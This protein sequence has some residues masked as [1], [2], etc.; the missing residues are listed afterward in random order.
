MPDL[1]QWLNKLGLGYIDYDPL[2]IAFT[3]RSYKGMGYN[4]EDNE[5]LEFLGDAVL[6]I[7]IAKVLFADP[8]LSESDMTELRKLYV[9]NDQLAVIFDLLDMKEFI[10]TAKNLKLTKKIKAGVVE[11]FF[12]VVFNEK[13]LS[14]CFLLW[15]RLHDILSGL[16]DF[17]YKNSY[18]GYQDLKN[19]KSTLQEFCLNL[20]F[21]LPEYKLVEKTGPD[22]APNFK[23]KLI[24]K[25]CSNKLGFEEIFETYSIIKPY[26]RTFGFGKNIKSAEMEAAE[27]MCERIG[28]KYISNY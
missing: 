15:N 17:N 27:E 12:G 9:S 13:S 10:R 25:P 21:D 1:G 19:A 24:L 6:D 5:R 14:D 7:I 28:L 26:V 20:N 16:D 4:G 11:A 22:H 18:I 3:H 23:V 8:D 2:W